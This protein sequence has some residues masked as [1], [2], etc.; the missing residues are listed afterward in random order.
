MLESTHPRE[1]GG[2]MSFGG[3]GGDLKREMRKRGKYERKRK[4]EESKR[5]IEVIRVK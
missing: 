2:R 3:G 1:M 5:E 4:K